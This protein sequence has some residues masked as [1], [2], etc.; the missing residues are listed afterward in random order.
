M[1]LINEINYTI[2]QIFHIKKSIKLKIKLTKRLIFIKV[3]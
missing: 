1:I 2:N 3:E